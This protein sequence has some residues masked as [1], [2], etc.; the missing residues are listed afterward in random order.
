MAELKTYIISTD[1][2]EGAIN[3]HRLDC[4]IRKSELVIGYDGFSTNEDSLIIYGDSITDTGLLDTLIEEHDSITPYA[5]YKILLD[6]EEDHRDFKTINYKTDLASGVSYTPVFHIHKSGVY[7]GLMEKTE[8]YKNFIDINN[9]GELILVVEESY[10]IDNSDA[11]VAYCARPALSR[12]KTWKWVK[13]DGTLDEINTKTRTKLYDTRSKRKIEGERRRSNII[14]QLIDNVGLGGV[15]SGAFTSADDAY[16]KLTALQELHSSAFTGWMSSG[17][18]SLVDLIL[19]DT[20]TAW[21]DVII[22]DTPTTQ[23]MIPWMIGYDFRDYIQMK[24]I[25]EIK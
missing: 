16:D 23:A 3:A 18:G 10:T 12:T 14:E 8:Y 7:A 22:P 19:Y 4:E 20:E 2:T 17:R 21:L 5:H 13:G 9:K 6:T 24:L 11:S 15:L 1:I 25:G